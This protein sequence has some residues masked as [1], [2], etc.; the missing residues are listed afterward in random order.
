[1]NLS[2]EALY[3]VLQIVWDAIG[4]IL[5]YLLLKHNGVI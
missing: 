1:M 3:L 5:I 4:T 2:S